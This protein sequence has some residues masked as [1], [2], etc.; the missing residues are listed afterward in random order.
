[1]EIRVCARK[2]LKGNLVSTVQFR[3]FH[4]IPLYGKAACSRNTARKRVPRLCV[5][6][7]IGIHHKKM[8]LKNMGNMESDE[9]ESAA[10]VSCW[11][12]RS[13]SVR[14][15]CVRGLDLDM[16][17]SAKECI[18]IVFT[19]HLAGAFGWPYLYEL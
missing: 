9:M 2:R 7:K 5:L 3:T 17:K 19:H 4:L 13:T 18:H 11:G 6:V 16:F 14:T 8:E 12:L 1:M 15:I 10:S